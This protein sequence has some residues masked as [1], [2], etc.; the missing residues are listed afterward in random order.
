MVR[1]LE[2][3][4]F[5]AKPLNGSIDVLVRCQRQ[6]GEIF[7][8]RYLLDATSVDRRPRYR[9]GYAPQHLV[10]PRYHG[11]SGDLQGGVDTFLNTGRTLLVHRV[12]GWS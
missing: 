1:G 7:Q 5:L 3:A 11:I 10:V 9:R 8:G 12:G 6:A 4:L 2:K